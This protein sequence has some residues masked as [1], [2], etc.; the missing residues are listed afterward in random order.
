MMPLTN[1]PSEGLPP[2]CTCVLMMPGTMYEARALSPGCRVH[3][4][5]SRPSSWPRNG[6]AVLRRRNGY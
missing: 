3:D 6:D 1:A 4:P 5:G 2:G